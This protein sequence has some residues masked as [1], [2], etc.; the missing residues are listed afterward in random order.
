MIAMEIWA[1]GGVAATSA[2]IPA[3]AAWGRKANCSCTTEPQLEGAPAAA[4]HMSRG[5]WLS[6]ACVTG[7]QPICSSFQVESI[8][9]IMMP[10]NWSATCTAALNSSSSCN[11]AAWVSHNSASA[12]RAMSRLDSAASQALC[13]W[14]NLSW[15]VHRPSHHPPHCASF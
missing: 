3:S 8:I 7:R 1:A 6:V 13:S 10:M 2:A 4:V 11:T 9:P 14:I 5:C 12:W 15:S